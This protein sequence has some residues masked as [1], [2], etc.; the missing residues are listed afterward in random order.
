LS[1]TQPPLTDF[2]KEGAD[3][4]PKP[5]V[6]KFSK[7]VAPL[8]LVGK[9]VNS[10]SSA[11]IGVGIN[12][13]PEIQ[14]TWRW[15]SDQQL[16]FT[17]K[18]DWPVGVEFKVVLA[19]NAVAP[20]VQLEKREFSFASAAFEPIVRK[21]EFYQDPVNPTLRKA[22]IE[23]GFSHPVNPAELEKR[24]ELRMA[25]QAEG[26]LGVGREKTP[27]TV[28]YDKLKLN[29]YVHSSVLAIPKESTTLGVTVDKDL[30]AAAGG[31]P[32]KSALST[33]VTVPGL[34]SLSMDNFAA[35]VVTNERYEPRNWCMSVRSTKASA[36]GCCRC[37]T[38][39]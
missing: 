9:V 3:R 28:S 17:P 34:Y 33:Q 15:A 16:E 38:R 12:V 1:V 10:G 18:A 2:A 23:L 5:M 26:V 30:V 27:F 24:I 8:A 6:V 7:S 11:G 35:Q 29:A 36:P 20:Q 22:V 32:S 13:T 31:A 39:R 25:G 14:G 21:A 37:K 4:L 19:A